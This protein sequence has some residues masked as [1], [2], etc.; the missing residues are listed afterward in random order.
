[1]MQLLNIL[2]V[3]LRKTDIVTRVGDSEICLLVRL[4]DESDVKI[5]YSRIDSRLSES[6]GEANY[7]LTYAIKPLA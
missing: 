5:L 7:T 3:S 6:V 4:S 2:K 1:M